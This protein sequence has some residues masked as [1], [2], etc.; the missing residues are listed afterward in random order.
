MTFR[1]ND[2]KDL[3]VVTLTAPLTVHG[4]AEKYVG[5]ADLSTIAQIAKYNGVSTTHRFKAGDEV[6][7][8]NVEPPQK[9][10]M[11]STGIDLEATGLN[12]P[13]S[14]PGI[15]TKTIDTTA[16][17]GPGGTF[18]APTPAD[19]RQPMQTTAQ[20]PYQ[21]SLLK[22]VKQNQPLLIGIGAGVLL[23]WLLRGRR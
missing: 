14:R 21:F 20:S 4:V 16:V 10:L 19:Y 6:D 13:T 11:S 23:W 3:G 7:I 1:A 22:F 2:E 15:V 5:S 17:P 12:T 9:D 18:M 8:S